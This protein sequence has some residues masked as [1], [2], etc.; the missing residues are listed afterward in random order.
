MFNSIIRL[1][2]AFD[3]G[4]ISESELQWHL[5]AHSIRSLALSVRLAQA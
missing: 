5:A 4:I 1:L 3:N 2:T